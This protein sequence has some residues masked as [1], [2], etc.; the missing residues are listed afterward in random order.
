MLGTREDLERLVFVKESGLRNQCSA[1]PQEHA[2]TARC[3]YCWFQNPMWTV[4]EGWRV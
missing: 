2:E 1:T 3:C 4:L